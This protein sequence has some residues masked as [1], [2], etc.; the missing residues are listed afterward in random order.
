MV[1]KLK[2]VFGL[3]D[4]RILAA[5]SIL[6]VFVTVG[7]SIAQF[8]DDSNTVDSY[9]DL[10]A[11]Y[12]NDR[13]SSYL[14]AV[15][16]WYLYSDQI[17]SVESIYGLGGFQD[18][19]DWYVDFGVGDYYYT[20]KSSIANY[21]EHG[22]RL[23]IYEDMLSGELVVLR[24][25]GND[26]EEEIVFKAPEWPELKKSEPL[27]NYLF[28]ELSMRRVVW[29]VTMKDV[30]L[31][32]E[33]YQTQLAAME[34]DEG[35]GGGQMMMLMGGGDEL[36]IA[37]MKKVTNGILLNIEY[38][39]SF[40]GTVWSAYSYDALAC[41]DTNIGG[42]GGD[43]SPPLPGT[44]EC[45]NCV[46]NCDIDPTNS[47]NGLIHAWTPV[48]T[49]LLLTGET[50]TAWTDT[51][52][53]ALDANTNPVHRF[54]AFG[55]N[56][57]D[58]DEDGLSDAFELL[59]VKSNPEDED[60][61][62]D[63][64][65]DGWEWSHGL[66]PLN[67]NDATEDP[68]DDGLNNLGEYLSGTE[69]NN[70]D[71]DG[72]RFTDG[73]E[74]DQNTDPLDDEGIPD[75][76]MIIN[77]D[78][79]YANSTNLSIRFP[80]YLAD[81]AIISEQSSLSNGVNMSYSDPMPFSLQGTS[82]GVRDVYA[83][84]S[85]NSVTSSLIQGS[86][87]FDNVP[88]E[89]GGFS[90]TNGQITN[91]RWI[92][93][94]GVATDA[95]SHVRVFVNS[96][97]AHGTTSTSFWHDRILLHQGANPLVVVA[98][99]MAGN[100]TSQTVEIV[101]NTTGDTTAPSL[102]ITLPGQS[103][104]NAPVIYGDHAPLFFQGSTDDETADVLAYTLVNSL[105]NGP[106]A[107]VVTG[108]QVWFN[109]SLEPGSN[110]LLVVASDAAF[111][112]TSITRM[113]VRDTNFFF[114]I[115]YPV[116]YQVMNASSTVVS[117]IASPMFLN[118]TITVNGVSTTISDHGSNVV[119]TTMA[120]V[121]LTQGRT[122]LIGE[123]V[124]NGVSYFTDPTVGDYDIIS[125]DQDLGYT[126]YYLFW[127]A[128]YG[129]ELHAV[130]HTRMRW[131]SSDIIYR[132]LHEYE[133]YFN[134]L[135]ANLIT[136]CD[137][138]PSVIDTIQYMQVPNFTLYLGSAAT[139]G[140]GGAVY[141]DFSVSLRNLDFRF[142]KRWPT[143][144]LQ[145]VILQFPD[146]R[147]L[148]NIPTFSPYPD[149]FVEDPSVITYRGQTGFWYN[150]K[151][152]FLV[153]IETEVEYS[154]SESDFTWPSFKG[155]DNYET[156][157]GKMLSFKPMISN[158]VVS[159]KLKELAFNGDKYH[160]VKSDD[161]SQDYDAPHW[162]DNSSPLDG[163]AD[164]SGDKK[165]PVAFTRN[166]KMKVSATWRIEPA[167]LNLAVK[168]KGDGPGNLDFPENIAVIDGDEVS[169]TDVECLNAFVN[170]VDFFDPMTIKWFFSVDG[171]TTWSSAG[172][173]ENQTY[174]T[175][176]DPQGVRYHTL[177]HLG[178][179]NAEGMT[180]EEDVFSAIWDEFTDLQVRRV[181]DTTLTYYADKF[182]QNTTL[183]Q[184]LTN[185]DGQCLAWCELLKAINDM[186]GISELTEISVFPA[187]YTTYNN[188]TSSAFEVSYENN[189]M[190]IKKWSISG[191]SPHADLDLNSNWIEDCDEDQFS[192][193]IFYGTQRK[194]FFPPHQD[195]FDSDNLEGVET[196]ITVSPSL[197]GQ[198]NVV[199]G[200]Q[201]F[202]THYLIKR[203]G[204]YYDPSYGVSFNSLLEWEDASVDGFW[205][206]V[207]E[208]TYPGGVETAY[209]EAGINDPALIYLKV[210]EY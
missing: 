76:F 129:Q 201:M 163:D 4:F 104:N 57:I 173:S 47:F 180:A 165:Y 22:T 178:C 187:A 190:L 13:E 21:V 81:D 54:Y 37:E 34:E 41:V 176:D 30:A 116:S 119:F 175:L 15:P 8:S 122:A 58:T 11:H 100:T 132:Y 87:I 130:S 7:W 98:Q 101:Q 196:I 140:K 39:V 186:H 193:N 55:N 36:A 67:S 177:L 59:T 188:S 141:D 114:T 62:G 151:V 207:Y 75:L 85:Q 91:H 113:V 184:L 185:Y 172:T 28:R 31:A 86:I 153:P 93:I 107:A 1:Q 60:T 106:W 120:G 125:I 38:T 143:Q 154:I 108:T 16:S 2:S 3:V 44:N 102:S 189:G 210:T 198:G 105:T 27:K 162:Q 148:A 45:T 197:Y 199:P 56:G 157:M 167:G 29:H 160:V 71:T 70:P 61:D 195:L 138:T 20:A 23:I 131:N 110:V 203:N 52:P 5:L 65:P 179:K 46:F 144:E 168:I 194:H 88:P 19:P 137:D 48:Y 149:L 135:Y 152:S 156:I 142:V 94:T 174:V 123:A 50:F 79:E 68:D 40:S 84:L 146:M 78:A 170:E 192:T 158:H 10:I 95:L 181:D 74:V 117:G 127:G 118:A 33:E 139:Y 202:D 12:L 63:E 124:L 205:N 109:V 9:D 191:P 103:T 134:C 204:K 115:T 32:D 96:Q 200:L 18:Q 145:Q 169:I 121:P 92:K 72:D 26:L 73:Y 161:G 97:W 42:G 43:G 182:C 155:S 164:D 89:L 112:S 128:S 90:P 208:I 24:E 133:Q 82:N 17:E 209:I 51:R 147:M 99:D 136:I 77:N 49:N 166:T 150:G 183:S 111:N 64:I 35:E 66:N 80:G 159:V 14:L 53:M 83:K 206:D 171:G 69:F 126:G 25:T 6:T